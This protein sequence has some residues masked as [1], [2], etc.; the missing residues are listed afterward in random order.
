VE[1]KEHL[2]NAIALN[3]S[4]FN[5]ARLIGPTIA[6]LVIGI[7][8][9]G[10]CFLLNSISFFAI[11][12]ALLAMK[13]HSENK[14]KQKPDI[15]KDMKEGF[16]YAFGSL[17]IKLTLLLTALVSLMGMSYG[18]LM[19]VFAKEIFHGGPHTL[20]FLM[21]ASGCGALMGA[22]T[23]ASKETDKGFEKIIP[24]GVCI[25]GIG[26]AG[27]SFSSNLYISMALIFLTGYGLLIF[28]TSSNT[29]IQNLVEEKMRGR[30]MSIYTMSFMGTMPFGSILAGYLASKIGVQ[31]SV[32]M[33]GLFCMLGALVF[34]IKIKKSEKHSLEA[35]SVKL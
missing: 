23:I 26:L 24:S 30:V 3:S 28:F 15:F 9:E 32:L 31:G 10:P 2:G 17:P 8:G 27:L 1:K 21:S 5:V 25:C 29:L 16:S 35:E 4:L 18:V 7:A 14:E 20:G 22:L 13:I 19:P 34:A 11:I 33:G 6:G 12:F